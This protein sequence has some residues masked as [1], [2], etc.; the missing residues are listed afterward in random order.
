MGA[1]NPYID[2]LTEQFD[3]LGDIT[4]RAMF[5]GYC[6]YC[7]GTVFALV[8]HNALYLKADDINREEFAKRGLPAFKPFE[9]RDE[10]MSYY[11]A[12]PEIF[13]DLDVMKHW[14]GGSVRAGLRAKESRRRTSR[15]PTPS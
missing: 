8:A 15:K 13:E 4:A 1:R 5:G 11:Q 10:V 14:V 12:P 2:F 6:L 9:N 3:P 7:D